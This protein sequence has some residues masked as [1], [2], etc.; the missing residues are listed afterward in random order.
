MLQRIKN[1]VGIEPIGSG[2][3]GDSQG[4]W[5]T[6]LDFSRDL[7]IAEKALL[8]VVMVSNPT[9]PPTNSLTVLKIQDIFEKLAQFNTA[10]GLN[11][12][13]YCSESVPGSGVIDQIE[14]HSSVL[15][16]LQQK[17]KV[18]S[19]YAKLIQ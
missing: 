19:E 11:L 14:L 2:D 9:F 10:T 12:K 8:D 18:V 3:V 15:L 6:Y 13:L 16:T 5:R 1:E 7:T 4:N 17:N